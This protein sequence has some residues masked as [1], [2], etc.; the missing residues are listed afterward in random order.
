M[1]LLLFSEGVARINKNWKFLVVTWSQASMVEVVKGSR[2]VTKSSQCWNNSW[3]RA[4]FKVWQLAGDWLKE[5]MLGSDLTERDWVYLFIYFKIGTVHINEQI[6]V[7]VPDYSHRLISIRCP[8]A[9]WWQTTVDIDTKTTYTVQD[10]NTCFFQVY[11]ILPCAPRTPASWQC[12]LGI[13]MSDTRCLSMQAES[14]LNAS[15]T[16]EKRSFGFH[17]KTQGNKE[18][19]W[20]ESQPFS[21]HTGRDDRFPLAA[22]FFMCGLNMSLHCI[23]LFSLPFSVAS[24]EWQEKWGKEGCYAAEVVNRFINF[25]VI[26]LCYVPFKGSHSSRMEKESHPA[27]SDST[28][29]WPCIAAHFHTTLILNPE[30]INLLYLLIFVCNNQTNLKVAWFIPS[31]LFLLINMQ[32]HMCVR[33][34]FW[35]KQCCLGTAFS[36]T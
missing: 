20:K 34:D 33:V 27:P 1:S 9:G 17:M 19:P 36:A 11:S 6:H 12:L 30:C 7:N 32:L 18:I 23:I 10:L 28:V 25:G 13:Y 14:Q 3:M 4:F 2:W 22:Q 26:N 15:S 35:W 29:C 8:W 16:F 21:T 24:E 5:S 31:K